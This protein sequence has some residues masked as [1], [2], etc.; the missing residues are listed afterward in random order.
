M[1][2]AYLYILLYEILCA[3]CIPIVLYTRVNN[4]KIIHALSGLLLHYYMFYTQPFSLFF[5]R[6]HFC[7]LYKSKKKIV[8]TH[9]IVIIVVFVSVESSRIRGYDLRENRLGREARDTDFAQNLALL[10]PSK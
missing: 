5:L 6:T 2:T 7:R 9:H 3:L 4:V 10:N 8:G 1:Y